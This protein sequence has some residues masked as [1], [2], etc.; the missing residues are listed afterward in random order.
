MP[1]DPRVCKVCN[2]SKP[3]SDFPLKTRKGIPYYLKTCQDCQREKDRVRARKYRAANRE[4]INHKARIDKWVR[5]Q[6]DPEFREKTKARSRD[7]SLK[8]YQ[9]N[10]E[11][12]LA[13]RREQ[14]KMAT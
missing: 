7:N 11:Q 14:R 13:R 6:T 3:P 9:K 10:R 8:Y 12:I 2:A 1:L 5:Y 4:E